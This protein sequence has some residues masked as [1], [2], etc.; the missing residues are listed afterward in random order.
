MKTIV[1][2]TAGI[3]LMSII[4]AWSEDRSADCDK[5]TYPQNIEG[6][7]VKVDGASRM[8]AMRASDGT[9]HEFRASGETLADYKIGDAIKAKLR[10]GQKCK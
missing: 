3:A 7:V 4:P 2:L 9:M 1:Y 10:M 5:T 8:L 6:R